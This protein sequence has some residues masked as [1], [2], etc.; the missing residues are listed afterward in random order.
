MA[1]LIDG[2]NLLH[3]TAI[4]GKGRGPGG[5]HRSR[6]GLLRFLASVIDDKERPRSTIVFDAAGAP[7]GLPRSVRHADMLVHY[8]AGYADAD[9]MIEELIASHDAPRTLLVVSSDHRIQRAARRRRAR[10]TDSDVW[11]AEMVRKRDAFADRDLPPAK[12]SE[13]PSAE[14]VAYWIERFA[15]GDARTS[16]KGRRLERE[17]PNRKRPSGADSRAEHKHLTGPDQPE[18]DPND[19]ANPFPP[20]YAEDFDEGGLF[21]EQSS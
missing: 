4:F 17:P 20:G 11:Y 3:V 5:L 13:T 12:P 15:D 16:S 8:A 2:Y 18:L 1:L 14:E 6:Q 10:F 7:P 19:L 9:A 21:D